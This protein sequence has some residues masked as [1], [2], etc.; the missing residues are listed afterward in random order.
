MSKV[1]EKITGGIEVNRD[2]ILLLTIGGLYSL[3]IA[4]S[5]TFVNVFLWKQSNG[6]FIYIALYNLAS[7]ILQPITFIIAGR[8]A[9]KMDRVIVLRLGV[10][11]LAIFFTA[12]LFFGNISAQNYFIFGILIGIGY[13]F[14][15]LAFNVLT[16]EITE[17]E[18]RD[19]FNGFLGLLTSFSGMVGPIFAGW[20]ITKMKQLT[21]YYFIFGISL[22]LFVIA[23]VL[24]FFL[25]RREVSG[26]FY[27]REIMAER[28]RNKNWG[29]I[30]HAHFFQGLREGTFIFVITLW[31]YIETTSE[32]ALGTY[33]LVSSATSF[34][35][36]FLA[37]RIIKPQFRKKAILIGGIGLY[38]S[39]LL[40]VFDVSFTKLIMYG[41]FISIAYPILLVPYISL[42]YD[43]I[44][45]GRN[46]REM[47]IEYI[48]VRDV[49]LNLGRITS[50][51]MFIMAITFFPEERAIPVVLM[52]LG[53]GHLIIYFYVRHIE[54]PLH[55]GGEMASFSRQKKEE[56][57]SSGTK[58]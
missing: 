45:K 28:K 49:F 44:G 13:G 6:E 15:W 36:Y 29:R 53:I 5:N 48:V 55:E 50:I 23:I 30:L 7:V 18:T 25:N 17:P 47:R 42:T 22:A 46:S 2:F 57:D 52:V 56:G 33:G 41:V 3:S 14:Y 39:L 35:V 37:T 20:I 10:I 12:V 54:L 43:V 24:S 32:L 58:I 9:K 8:W 31:V 1:L 26:K 38:A 19:F 4:L 34:V 51:V 16:F 40:I 11:F 27:F 21:G